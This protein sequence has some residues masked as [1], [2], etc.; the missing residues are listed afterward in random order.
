MTGSKDWGGSDREGGNTLHS[1]GESLSREY[2]VVI[3]PLVF[4]W[5]RFHLEV[6]AC[7]SVHTSL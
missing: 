1:V 5:I 2:R 4:A 3:A 6:P 7:E